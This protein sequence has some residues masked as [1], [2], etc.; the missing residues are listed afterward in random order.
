[1]DLENFQKFFKILVKFL[2]F[3]DNF[4][5]K[6]CNSFPV[7]ILA[8]HL[9]LI[10]TSNG[11]HR[12]PLAFFLREIWSTKNG[13]KF[14]FFYKKFSKI[15]FLS[16]FHEKSPLLDPHF[17]LTPDIFYHG[18]QRSKVNQ[19]GEKVKNHQ[20]LSKILKFF[21]NLTSITPDLTGCL[22]VPTSAQHLILIRKNFFSYKKWDF[23]AIFL[24]KSKSDPPNLSKSATT[25]SSIK[26]CHK[27]KVIFSPIQGRMQKIR[28]SYYQDHEN[29]S[30]FFFWWYMKRILEPGR[31][32]TPPSKRE[33]AQTATT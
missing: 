9:Q 27:E 23:L 31:A 25:R 10:G 20:K 8:C 5:G 15:S 21:K 33:N 32:P 29:P 19:F 1:M 3:F 26:K 12:T 18:Q 28:K 30:D 14:N 2:N 24:K 7:F 6:S 11:F 17:F 13:Q 16:C 4:F 22:N